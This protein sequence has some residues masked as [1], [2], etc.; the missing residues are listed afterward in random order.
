MTQAD[1][2]PFVERMIARYEG[3]Y[4]WDAGDSGGP[5]KYGI[6]C[7]DLAEHRNEKMTSMARWRHSPRRSVREPRSSR[8]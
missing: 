5:T 1:Y 8:Y 4:G 6:T 2:T 7:Y 3:N